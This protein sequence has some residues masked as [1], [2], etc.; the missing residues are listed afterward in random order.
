LAYVGLP[1]GGALLATGIAL[2]V[3]SKRGSKKKPE[4]EKV[5][6]APMFGPGGSGMAISGRF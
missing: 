1:I 6:F 4:E 5:T 2:L 3:V